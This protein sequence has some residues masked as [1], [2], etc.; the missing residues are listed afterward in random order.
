MVTQNA[1]PNLFELHGHETHITYSTTS[2]AGKPQLVYRNN[3]QNYSFSG[4][5]IRTQD[6][7]LGT[8]VSVS[9]VRTIDQGSTS[10]TLVVPSVNLAGEQQQHIKTLAVVTKH[11]VGIQPL[12][13]GARELYHE[14]SLEGK[15]ELVQF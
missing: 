10:L 9:L 11:L 1:E 7:E 15:A 6:S 12:Q 2:T 3:E 8:L 13:K 5:E 14:V 4:D